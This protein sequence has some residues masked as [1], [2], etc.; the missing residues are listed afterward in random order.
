M[1]V[2]TARP[3]RTVDPR[4][5]VEFLV[6]RLAYFMIPR[7]VRVVT[8]IPKT[9]TN[10]PRKVVFRDQGLTADTWDREAAGLHLQRD[11]LGT[12]GK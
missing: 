10:K 2:V 3:G 12:G 5:L 1:A 6:P 7:Y 4:A 8:E 9:E 11:R